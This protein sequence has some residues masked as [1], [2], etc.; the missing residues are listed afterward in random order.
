[1]CAFLYLALVVITNLH[2][3]AVR[4]H[5]CD[6]LIAQ[7]YVTFGQQ[8]KRDKLVLLNICPVFLGEQIFIHPVSPSF[9]NN[10]SAMLVLV[11]A[12]FENA[13]AKIIA[14]PFHHLRYGLAV[15]RL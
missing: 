14:L 13:A 4:N 3:V 8:P 9:G 6:L 2:Y 15:P 7:T 11:E 10:D 12:F 5:L 1:M